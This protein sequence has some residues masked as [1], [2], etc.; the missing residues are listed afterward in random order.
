ML[1]WQQ[2]RSSGAWLLYVCDQ[3][4]HRVSVFDA[5]SGAHVR[6][7]GEGYMVKPTRLALH[8]PHVGSAEPTLLFVSCCAE[9]VVKSFDADSGVLLRTIGAGL[10]RP[11]N[12]QRGLAVR[13]AAPGSGMQSLMYVADAGNNCIQV[14][15]VDSGAHLRIIG[16]GVAGS[17]VGQLDHPFGITLQEPT[18][19]SGSPSLLYVADMGNDRVQVFDADT[20][21]HVRTI[22]AGEGNEVGE[23]CQPSSVTLHPGGNDTLLLFVAEYGNGRVQVFVV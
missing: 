8:Q 19:G 20:G 9:R 23:M 15:D 12:G 7:I 22:G 17:G 5:D 18:P 14:F 11:M 16:T 4:E 1:I 6:T 21:A 10:V 13:M 2:V 3:N